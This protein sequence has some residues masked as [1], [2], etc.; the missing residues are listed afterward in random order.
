M[1]QTVPQGALVKAEM[2]IRIPTEATHEQIDEWVQFEVG[3]YGGMALDN[4]L[5]GEAPEPW[6][7]DVILTE[8]NHI[9]T[10]E[11][12]LIEE[13]DDGSKRYRVTRTLT[14]Y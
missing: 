6:Q 10:E 11:R 9:G 4:P 13:N 3:Q 5:S 7:G 14:P 1:T 12:T 8:L 2:V